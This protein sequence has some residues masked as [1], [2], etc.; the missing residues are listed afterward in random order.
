MIDMIRA[1]ANSLFDRLVEEGVKIS[2]DPVLQDENGTI[3][4][5]SLDLSDTGDTDNILVFANEFCEDHYPQEYNQVSTK[6]VQILMTDLMIK[7]YKNI[8]VDLAAMFHVGEND[9]PSLTMRLLKFTYYFGD[10]C[11][12]SVN[13]MNIFFKFIQ[14]VEKE[15]VSAPKEEDE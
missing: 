2:E 7:E 1:Y 9:Q 6:S 15:S 4:S 3:V 5:Y 11:K 14:T 8:A 10:G 12:Y 13:D